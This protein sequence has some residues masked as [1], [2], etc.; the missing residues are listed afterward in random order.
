MAE[1]YILENLGLSDYEAGVVE[2]TFYQEDPVQLWDL[3]DPLRAN[4][5]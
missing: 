2:K 1:S 5:A 4:L 3:K